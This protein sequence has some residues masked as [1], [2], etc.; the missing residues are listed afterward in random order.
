MVITSL[1]LTGFRS[2]LDAEFE[3]GD[4]VNIVVGPNASGKTNLLEA[5]L[6]TCLGKSYRAETA[7]LVNNESNL[8]RIQSTYK[9]G[10]RVITIE[11]HDGHSVRRLLVNGSEHAR[12]R[13]D[14]TLPVVLFEPQH[15][16]L[17]NGSPSS[18]RAYLDGI[19]E[20][21]VTGYKSALARFTRALAQRNR[22]LK[23]A[24]V[25]EQ[26]FFVWDMK[27][28]EYASEIIHWRRQ[29]V[30]RLNAVL[31]SHYASIA[32]RQTPIVASYHSTI[33]AK[34]YQTGLLA[35]LHR[36][37]ADEQL[38]G[39]TLSGPHRDDLRIELNHQPAEISASRGES[40]SIV[41]SLKLAEMSIL[42]D[43]HD[44]SPLI[45]LDDVFSELDKDR[46]KA[47]AATLKDHQT[48]ITTTNADAWVRFGNKHFETI[49]LGG[50]AA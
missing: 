42:Q 15:M 17:V 19:L 50:N 28:A 29:L 2:Y 1:Q 8:A 10:D 7:D 26:Q 44:A 18:R 20:S 34:D 11:K 13:R 37:R 41:L 24:G 30:D 21:T 49:V 5:L 6:V 4:G 16:M 43:S 25:S 9:D 35:A 31:P 22:L 14:D 39:Y 23:T 40:R 12:W 3:F 46:Q 48:I 47:L 33:G 36:R 45:L 38:R 27:F 32:G